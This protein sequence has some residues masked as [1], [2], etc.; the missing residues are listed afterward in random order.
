MLLEICTGSIESVI[1]ARDG[2]AQRVELC[3]ALSEGGVTPSVGLMRAARR[4]EGLK[5]HVLIRPRGGDFL[6]S[7]EEIAIMTDD[8]KAARDCGADGVVIGALNPDGTIDTDACAEMIAA[9]E[10]MSIT[11]HRAFDMV[12]DA[13]SALE[14]AVRLGCRRI[15]TS[16]LQPTAEKGIPMLRHLVEKAEDRIIIMPGSGVSPL[17]AGKIISMTGAVE[18]HASAR[19]ERRSGMSY[20]NSAVT[21][22]AK[23]ADEFLRL[24]TDKEIVET[25]IKNLKQ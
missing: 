1:A 13:D 2:G 11:F 23:D 12:S 17:N 4:V 22:G 9:A 21:M 10:G 6:Y 8:I 3:S 19:S 20:R 16:G 5:M 18:I 24:E 25:I 7:R 15:L 14:T